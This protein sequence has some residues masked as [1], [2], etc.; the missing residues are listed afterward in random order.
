MYFNDF[1][2]M[3]KIVWV[4][5]CEISL[6][7]V[8]IHEND[9]RPQAKI[10]NYAF[11]NSNI[12]IEGLFWKRNDYFTRKKFKTQKNNFINKFYFWPNFF[13]I[14]SYQILKNYAI[15]I[16]YK[17][18]FEEKDPLQHKHFQFSKINKLL[19]NSAICL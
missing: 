7:V 19:S 10:D 4:Y 1:W 11:K 17:S 18:L 14:T 8:F 2:V 16:N 13:L 9:C 3:R 12:I 6:K 5:N 15:L